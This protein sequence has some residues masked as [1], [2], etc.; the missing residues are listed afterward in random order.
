MFNGPFCGATTRQA[1]FDDDDANAWGVVIDWLY[2]GILPEF[3][4]SRLTLG[5]TSHHR[6]QGR[7]HGRKARAGQPTR[8]AST[9]G[10]T[11]TTLVLLPARFGRPTFEYQCDAQDADSVFSTP[12]QKWPL[13][14]C[15]W[16]HIC[17][18]EP[19]EGISAD[20][21]HLLEMY[22]KFPA[23]AG[24]YAE[25]INGG[26]SSTTDGD[27]GSSPDK[28]TG[29][30][31]DSEGREQEKENARTARTAGEE[32][33]QDGD[34][35]LEAQ[36]IQAMLDYLVTVENIPVPIPYPSHIAAE[37]LQLTLLKVLLL[38][39]KYCWGGLFNAAMDAYR[40][41]EDQLARPHPVRRHVE[42]AYEF[43]P[44]TSPLV[45]LMAD[46]AFYLAAATPGS[47]GWMDDVVQRYPDFWADIV[48]RR[49]G[50]VAVPGFN[51]HG[52][53]RISGCRGPTGR[54]GG[55]T[56]HRSEGGGT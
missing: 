49:E 21:L 1:T 45:A 4:P 36:R 47:D 32:K 46:T 18:Q 15:D 12:G 40:R 14:R 51:R 25:F 42:L 13:Y 6:K 8:A 19:Y 2:T 30:T 28:K 31:K 3:D 37:F 24:R 48:R 56:Y 38:A 27:D 54:V 52:G 5:L 34:G 43:C 41:G 39:D 33:G 44:A 11:P 7:L 50:K 53:V 23:L 22:E 10:S 55:A 26:F 35:K 20:E 29:E 9:S 17:A 16:Q